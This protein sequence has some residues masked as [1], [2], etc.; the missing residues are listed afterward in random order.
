[1][2]DGL[3]QNICDNEKFR[4][5]QLWIAKFLQGALVLFALAILGRHNP[6]I[7]FYYFNLFLIFMFFSISNPWSFTWYYSWF[8]I[9]PAFVVALLIEKLLAIRFPKRDLFARPVLALFVIYILIFGVV[10][11]NRTFYWPDYKERLLTY[12]KAAEF[13]NT[14]KGNLKTIAIYE[15]GIFGYHYFRKSKI[16]DLGGLLSDEP[17][18]YY[19]LDSSDRSRCYIWGSIPPKSV[20]ELKPDCLVTLDCFTDNGLFKNEEFLRRYKLIRYWLCYTWGS[21]GMYIFVRDDNVNE[22]LKN[23]IDIQSSEQKIILKEKSK[24]ESSNK[25]KNEDEGD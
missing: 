11:Q 16:I 14:A 8:A 17:L 13:L 2:F 22:N 10:W 19:P 18:K 12:K 1:M 25:V 6:I 23:L 5:T 3:A 9:A 20:M 15:P 24:P 21:N 7:R 4:V